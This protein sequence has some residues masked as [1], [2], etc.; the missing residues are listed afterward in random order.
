M[1]VALSVVL[2]RSACYDVMT[3]DIR[4]L[5]ILKY[6]VVKRQLASDLL[7]G[8]YDTNTDVNGIVALQM[9]YCPSWT[10]FCRVSMYVAL[11]VYNEV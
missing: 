10:S 8:N 4:Q 11:K 9:R 5:S 6:E 3:V 2:I 1:L 7:F